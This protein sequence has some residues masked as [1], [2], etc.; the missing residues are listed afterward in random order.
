MSH[1]DPARRRHL[2]TWRP[3]Q[4][5]WHLHSVAGSGTPLL[6]LASN[7]YLGLSRH[8]DLVNAATAAL[9]LV[10]STSAWPKRKIGG[11]GLTAS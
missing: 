11:A 10:K 2:R 9:R 1:V 6:D 5:H 4:E 8:P 3:G 7:D